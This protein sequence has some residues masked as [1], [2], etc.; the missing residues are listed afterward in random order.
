MDVAGFDAETAE[1]GGRGKAHE[2]GGPWR[3][4]SRMPRRVQSPSTRP[5][6]PRML[7]ARNRKV[8]PN[9]GCGKPSRGH[10]GIISMAFTFGRPV[11]RPAPFFMRAAR[12]GRKVL[13][14]PPCLPPDGMPL[15]TPGRFAKL[16][17]APNS[18]PRSGPSE[19]G[20]RTVRLGDNP[21]RPVPDAFLPVF[22]AL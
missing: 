18:S 10:D 11:R 9:E 16:W 2:R 6:P 14:P 4:R 8:R 20:K 3:P 12:E 13:H 7:P 17:P 1:A 22:L 19:G 5:L 21:P 15:S